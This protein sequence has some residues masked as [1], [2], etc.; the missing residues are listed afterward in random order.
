MALSPSTLYRVAAVNLG[1][2]QNPL[3]LNSWFQPP[4]ANCQNDALP[5]EER[6]AKNP[7][8]YFERNVRNTV[9]LAKA[10]GVIPVISTWAYYLDQARP[11]YW[12]KAVDEQNE[13][14]RKIAGEQEVALYDMAANLPLKPEYW[15]GD[16]IHMF[17]P[18]THEQAAQYAKFL[19]EE[20]LIPEAS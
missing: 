17:L 14:L 4:E 16:G 8:I 3:A 2:M 12:R 1:W 20:Q 10:N 5:V 19:V 15:S 13:I 7:P 6:V 18:G 9:V 11:D